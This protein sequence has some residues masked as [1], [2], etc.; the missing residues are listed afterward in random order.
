MSVTGEPVPS[1]VW[2]GAWNPMLYIKRKFQELNKDDC[3]DVLCF[4]YTSIHDF[5][6]L[7]PWVYCDSICHKESLRQCVL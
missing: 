5:P 4:S 2:P 7:L 3:D 6:F 1:S